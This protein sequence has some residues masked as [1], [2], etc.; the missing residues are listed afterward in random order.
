MDEVIA[1]LEVFGVFV[2]ILLRVGVPLACALV[3]FGVTMLVSWLKS[4]TKS[5]KL[6]SALDAFQTAVEDIAVTVEQLF[7]GSGSEQ[8]RAAFEEICAKK[9]LNVADA[10]KYLETHIIP[11]SKS[12]N[13]VEFAVDDDDITTD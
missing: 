9:G 8:K 3:T 4:K 7:D 1:F 11:T 12:I 5:K 2:E 13:I 10:V 6:K